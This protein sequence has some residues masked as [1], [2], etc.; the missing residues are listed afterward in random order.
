M[1]AFPHTK[2]F[3]D[4]HDND[5]MNGMDLRDYFAAKAMQSMVQDHA[6]KNTIIDIG[7]SIPKVIS[8]SAYEYADAMLKARA[9]E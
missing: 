8:K 6:L 5:F 7:G 9:A 1:K 2:H 4:T 3:S